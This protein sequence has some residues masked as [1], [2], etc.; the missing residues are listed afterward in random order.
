MIAYEVDLVTPA[1]QTVYCG[2][3]A[4][5]APDSHGRY[6]A[7]FAYDHSYLEWPQCFALDPISLPLGP[8]PVQAQQ[9]YPPLAIFE[10]ALPDRWGRRLM[11]QL[12]QLP[13]KQRCEPVYLGLLGDAGLGALRFRGLQSAP[14]PAKPMAASATLDEL[15]EASAAFERH[16][17]TSTPALEHLL[18]AGRTPG[19]ARPKALLNVGQEAWLAKF[20][21]CGA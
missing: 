17:W 10:D 5:T 21:Q 2:R 9:L 3:L 16:E 13:A 11:D 15:L 1:G 12:H 6:R 7:E 19:G 20:P 4:L 14:E 8:A 18:R